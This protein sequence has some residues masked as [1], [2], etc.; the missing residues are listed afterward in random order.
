M[1]QGAR[2]S[3]AGQDQG[4]ANNILSS[5][6]GVMFIQIVKDDGFSTEW[7]SVE[8]TIGRGGLLPKEEAEEISKKV[9]KMSNVVQ[10]VVMEM[11]RS[12]TECGPKWGH[13]IAD[14]RAEKITQGGN[15]AENQSASRQ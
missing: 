11:I 7:V 12:K 10:V 14:K 9:S 5:S 15:D 2:E 6:V 8:S 1:A 3:P 4:I 13:P